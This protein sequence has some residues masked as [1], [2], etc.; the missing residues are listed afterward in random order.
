MTDMPFY[1]TCEILNI[2][3]IFPTLNR[4]IVEYFVDCLNLQTSLIQIMPLNDAQVFFVFL[5]TWQTF[6]G[7]RMIL[8]LPMD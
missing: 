1:P 5:P 8:K 3:S 4:S 6:F 2:L 7:W